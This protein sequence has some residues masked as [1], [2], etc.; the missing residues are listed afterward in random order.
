MNT[1]LKN[2]LSLFSTDIAVRIIGFI[3]TAYLARVLGKSGFGEIN[4]ALSVLT[5]SSILSNSG[6][7]LLG[8]RKVITQKEKIDSVAGEIFYTR[9]ILTLLIFLV[10]SIICYLFVNSE[11]NKIIL[12]YLL[13]LFP[14]AFL[15][16]W[17]FTGYQKMDTLS[18][19]RIVGMI[20]YL[21]FILLFVNS[22][23][24]AALSGIG[25]TLGGLVNA[26]LLWSVYRR[27]GFSTKLIRSDFKIFTL[28]KETFPLGAAGFISQFYIAFPII[29]LGITATN[30]D[31][32]SFSAAFKIITLFLIFDRVFN[33]IFF[34]KITSLMS[35]SPESLEE[36][37]NKI[38]K[39][40]SV[41]S[42]FIAMIVIITGEYIITTAFGK[43]YVDAVIILQVLTGYLLFTLLNSVFTYTFIGMHKDKVYTF[44]LLLALPVFILLTFSLTP[45][46]G[47]MGVVYSF[48]FFDLVSMVYM[49]FKLKKIITIKFF[50]TVV[51][52]L[53]ITFGIVLPIFYLSQ[54]SFYFEIILIT[55]IY[56]PLIALIA[57]INKSEINFLRRV[58][59]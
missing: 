8:T 4:I 1:N 24:D 26:Y 27:F 54:L 46:F 35:G 19:G 10:T 56:L 12:F 22:P 44:S 37:F 36:V 48:I 18:I 47:T 39:I 49:L 41:F 9:F 23:D 59:T 52:P 31:V 3:A 42:L 2:I 28:L 32:G 38:L 50:R 43:A 15:L 21:A 29:Y 30:S 40:I 45:F 51:F 58:L 14:S 33:F 20:T 55:L 11:L 34:P 7:V 16:E 13:F 53:F 17:F 5:Y 57:G 6:L 25:W